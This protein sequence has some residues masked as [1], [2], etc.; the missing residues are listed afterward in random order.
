MDFHKR[1]SNVREE[2]IKQNIASVIITNPDQQF[3]LC[4][5]KA[6]IYSRPITLVIEREQTFL[7]VPKLEE[8]HAK[9]IAIVDHV[10]TYYEHPASQR[11]ET[12]QLEFLKNILGTLPNR[13]SI[14]IDLSHTSG[15]LIRFI[16]ELGCSVTDIGKHIS[17]MRY[18]KDQ[19]ELARIREAGKLVSQA[20]R[21]S[22]E[23]IREGISEL[24]IDAAGNRELFLEASTKYPEAALNL[25]VMTPSGPVRSV[26]PHL[27]SNT[28]KLGAGDVLIHTRQVELNGYRAEL[29]RT[30]IVGKAIAEQRR[31]FEAARK[32]QLIAIE[33]IKPGIKAADV[34]LLAREVLEQAGY[35]KYAIHRIGH[36]IG[37]SA[38][39]KPYLR[40]DNELVLSEGMVFSIEPGIIFPE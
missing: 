19:D 14:G 36:G 37:I 8:L 18:I 9:E 22:M 15:N 30:A 29:E 20:V 23:Q 2:M 28:R 26:M 7:I 39:E 21:V 34:D 10:L 17:K 4:G 40:F 33:A 3:Y 35:G 27:Y 38:H 31:A 24:E 12:N 25:N 1:L 16:E 32:A 5:F 13:S 11:Q 6:F